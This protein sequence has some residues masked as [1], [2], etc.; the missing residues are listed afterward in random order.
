MSKKKRIAALSIGDEQNKN[1]SDTG[2]GFWSG[3]EGFERLGVIGLCL[4]LV[5]GVMG[6]DLGDS[7]IKT[8]TG[9]ADN[10]STDGSNSSSSESSLLSN[11]NPFSAAPSPT[12]TPLQLSKEYV[13][14][15]GR[16]LAVEDANASAAPPADLAVWRPSSGTW[17]VLGGQGSE[18]VSQQ[19]GLQNDQPVP[20]DYD[21]DGKTDF[22]VYREVTSGTSQLYMLYSS[23]GSDVVN[24]GSETHNDR[25]V[26]GDF[27]GD[28]RSDPAVYRP[29]TGYWYILESST[30]NTRIE[31][32]GISTDTPTPKDF[33]GDGRDDIAVWR[34][35]E[36]SQGNDLG[37]WYVKQSSD[38]SL[39]IITFG[40]TGDKPVPGDYDGDG[41]ADL[42]Y[43]KP[44]NGT[45]YIFQSSTSSMVSHQF[46]NSTDTLV[47]N[48]YDG[49]GKTDAAVWRLE[50]VGGTTI[51]KWYI[52]NSSDASMRVETFGLPGDIPVP[53]LYRR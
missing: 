9:D 5:V 15:G 4:L 3:L 30:S 46:G 25:P 24:L 52:R 31:Q 50:T 26:T 41:R 10:A 36:S 53:A 34:G 33:D 37:N 14:A 28:G 32:F 8:F 12:P 45:W 16:M 19:W 43:Y 2:S 35:V 38:S 39:S 27:D 40:T 21:G 13:Y 17:W 22:C 44:S 51:G 1:T 11:L 7:I 6:S 42:T 47:Q 20:G 29:A 49:D 48:D 23:G 18:S